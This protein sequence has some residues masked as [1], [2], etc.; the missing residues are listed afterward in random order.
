MS[1]GWVSCMKG[2]GLTEEGGTLAMNEVYSSTGAI[3]VELSLDRT[4]KKGRGAGVAC[5][6]SWMDVSWSDGEF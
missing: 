2:E 3:S 1:V 5:S 4:R 6:C